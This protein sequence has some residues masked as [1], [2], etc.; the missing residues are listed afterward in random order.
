MQASVPSVNHTLPGLDNDFN[1]LSNAS[2]D[3]VLFKGGRIY[4]H[5]ILCVNYT[6]YDVRRNQDVLNPNSDHCD[7]MM[8]FAPEGMEE[9]MQHHFCYARV[10]GIYHANVQYISPGFNSYNAH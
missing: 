1:A 4:Q 9:G 7:I 3:Q 2:I 10:V 5:N 6:T 8:L